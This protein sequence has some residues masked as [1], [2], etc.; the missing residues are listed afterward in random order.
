MRDAH[1]RP[2]ENVAERR[3]FLATWDMF[4]DPSVDPGIEPSAAKAALG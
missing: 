3:G 4:V 1:S 2:D